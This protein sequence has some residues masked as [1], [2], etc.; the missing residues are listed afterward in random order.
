MPRTNTRQDEVDTPA[1]DYDRM[2]EDWELIHDLLGGTRQMRRR[3]EVWLPREP[4]EKM[5]SY[6]IRLNRSFLYNGL[7]DTIKK[8]TSKPFGRPT[9]IEGIDG[10]EELEAIS[11]NMDLQGTGQ[12]QFSRD[13]FQSGVTYGKYHIFVDF[14]QVPEGFTRQDE[15]KLK[16]RPFF[17]NISATQ[18]IGWKSETTRAGE[19]RLVEIRFREV[20]TEPDG[21]WKEMRVHWLYVYRVGDSSG[22]VQMW[23]S[24]ERDPDVSQTA[25][26]DYFQTTEAADPREWT[27][28]KTA[29]FT[30]KLDGVPTIPLVTVYF[31]RKGFMTSEPP[32]VDLAW[33]NL[34]H[35]QSFSDQRNILRFAR[36][37]QIFTK[38]FKKDDLKTTT[39]ASV[40]QQWNAKDVKAD[41]KYVEHTGK[42]IGAGEEDLK[43]LEDRMEVLGMQP[44][45]EKKADQTATGV[46]T[47]EGWKSSDILAWVESSEIGMLAAWMYAFAWMGR[48]PPKDF[49]FNIYSDFSVGIG[50]GEDFNQLHEL[51]KN[52]DLTRKTILK[53]AKRRGMLAETVDVDAEDEAVSQEAADSLLTPV[54]DDTKKTGEGG[55]EE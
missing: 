53:E 14:P 26:I 13:G 42:A 52:G 37:A 15:I 55:D 6:R 40:N 1:I 29:P 44:L 23:K 39:T 51:R 31:N 27:L 9:T 17:K 11:K 3:A 18:L 25:S 49:D 4:D 10:E 5:T 38:G 46:L 21:E 16:P 35:W 8:L 2:H 19:Q 45:V 41:V 50:R 7:K 12:T 48:E 30:F 22:E 20:S 54:D 24:V 32:L 43:K 36:L 34:V 33:M 28:V 47:N